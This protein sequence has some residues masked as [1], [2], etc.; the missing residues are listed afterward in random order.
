[1]RE[2]GL[3]QGNSM[4]HIDMPL[5]QGA[6]RL[7]RMGMH[8]LAQKVHVSGF[9]NRHH[10]NNTRSAGKVT[11]KLSGFGWP[12]WTEVV[13][14]SG[15]R[16]VRVGAH[17]GV[18]KACGSDGPGWRCPRPWAACPEMNRHR[19]CRPAGLFLCR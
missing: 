18:P 17:R 13:K 10:I 6:E 4:N 3:T 1:M 14:G 5:H 2:G 11:G 9:H 12:K 16:D 19:D 8:V 15:V 7:L